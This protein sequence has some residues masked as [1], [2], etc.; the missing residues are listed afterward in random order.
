M[1]AEKKEAKDLESWIYEQEFPTVGHEA[2]GYAWI[3]IFLYGIFTVLASAFTYT[4]FETGY[5]YYDLGIHMARIFTNILALIDYAAQ[6]GII[7][8]SKAWNAYGPMDLY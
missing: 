4:S 5:R 6:A 7:N 8:P 3:Y 2:T 1:E